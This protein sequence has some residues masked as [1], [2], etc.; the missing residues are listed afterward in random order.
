MQ[1]GLSMSHAG[2]R[3]ASAPPPRLPGGEGCS[4]PLLDLTSPPSAPAPGA[5]RSPRCVQLTRRNISINF[6]RM[7]D[8]AAV[9]LLEV[10][11]I[12]RSFP[13]ALIL[14]LPQHWHFLLGPVP[15]GQGKGRM[16][17]HAALAHLPAGCTMGA[18][19]W[20]GRPSGVEFHSIM[21]VLAC[22]S[23]GEQECVHALQAAVVF[24]LVE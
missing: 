13:Y 6:N 5:S 11:R 22:S 4:S 2:V 21:H 7:Y 12:A 17:V 10:R 19:P 16:S 1:L 3:S 24:I 23:F 15:W 9:L 18:G 20:A 14:L 8:V